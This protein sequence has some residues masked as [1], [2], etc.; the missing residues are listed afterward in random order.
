[1]KTVLTVTHNPATNSWGYTNTRV[2]DDGTTQGGPVQ[3]F[4]E[5]TR[6]VQQEFGNLLYNG[7]VQVVEANGQ[8]HEYA[9]GCHLVQAENLDG[10]PGPI[11]S[12]GKEEF[13]EWSGL[14]PNLN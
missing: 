10:T 9:D 11:G 13:A 7:T 12:M 5:H 4:N 2:N 6:A 8:V 14:D 1:M 3:E